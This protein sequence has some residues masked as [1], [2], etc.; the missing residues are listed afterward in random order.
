MQS[1]R[2]YQ[3]RLLVLSITLLVLGI[4]NTIIGMQK[5]RQYRTIVAEGR[6]RGYFPDA[7]GSK[8]RIL[9][10]LDD[11]GE[12]YNIGRAK[13][14]LYHVVLSGGLIMMAVGVILCII[15]WLRLRL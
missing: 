3:S 12:R 11:E 13:I 5:L 15:A 9:R 4:G 14:D 7:A 1:R 10:P 2:L 6:A 8:D